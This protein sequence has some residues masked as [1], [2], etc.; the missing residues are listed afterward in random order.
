MCEDC[1]LRR[2]LDCSVDGLSVA[3]HQAL[4][5]CPHVSGPR[6][7]SKSK[8]GRLRICGDVPEDTQSPPTPPRPIHEWPLAARAI[9]ALRDDS[10]KGLGDTIHR[11]LQRFGADAMTKLYRRV[12]GRD[13][14][15]GDRQAKLNRMFPYD[16]SGT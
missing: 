7:G 1:E 4:F 13:C 16:A 9:A 11:H 8:P 3:C 2:G 12:M 10:D 5:F 6:F 15:C 14:G